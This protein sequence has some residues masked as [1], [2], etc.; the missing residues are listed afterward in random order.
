M[1]TPHA[2]S[3]QP[4]RGTGQGRDAIAL[5][6]AGRRAPAGMKLLPLRLLQV[7]V[8]G[9]YEEFVLLQFAQA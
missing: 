5:W 1:S 4:G 3:R 8:L 7:V 2:H 9:E 6:L